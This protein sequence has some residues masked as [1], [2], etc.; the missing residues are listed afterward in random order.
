M[1]VNNET[2]YVSETRRVSGVDVYVNIQLLIHVRLVHTNILSVKQFGLKYTHVPIPV[3]MQ[4][5]RWVCGHSLD[6]T[7]GLNP[8]GGMVV[9]V[10]CVLSSRGLCV[11][12]ITTQQISTKL[13]VSNE[14]DCKAL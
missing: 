11:G 10:S 2:F 12:L 6:E 8:A 3:A 1:R 9:F 14:C 4:S 13:S 7:V 5:K